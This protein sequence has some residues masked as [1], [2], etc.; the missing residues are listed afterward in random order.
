MRQVPNRKTIARQVTLKNHLNSGWVSRQVLIIFRKRGR[1]VVVLLII[2]RLRVMS[3]NLY[4]RRKKLDCHS[5]MRNTLLKKTV[6]CIKK[7][8]VIR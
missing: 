2:E 6:G 4:M 1:Q 3:I 8:Q 7:V 5:L